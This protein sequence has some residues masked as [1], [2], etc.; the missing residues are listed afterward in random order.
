MCYTIEHGKSE[1]GGLPSTGRE[2]N[3]PV[4]RRE[5]DKMVTY[6][7]MF[8]FVSIIIALVGLCYQIFKDKK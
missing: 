6:E 1:P 2:Q 5:G 4:L 8:L 3:P 7:A